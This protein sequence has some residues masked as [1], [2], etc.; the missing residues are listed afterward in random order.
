[1]LSDTFGGNVQGTPKRRIFVFL[2]VFLSKYKKHRHYLNKILDYI[3]A[4][5]EKNVIE[6]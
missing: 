2:M 1:M 3:F 4:N 5:S 6:N